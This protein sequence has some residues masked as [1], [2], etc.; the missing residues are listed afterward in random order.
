MVICLPEAA[1][2]WAQVFQLQSCI[3][4]PTR[5]NPAFRVFLQ[6]PRFREGLLV[7]ASHSSVLYPFFF[8]KPLLKVH[9]FLLASQIG[10]EAQA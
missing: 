3:V 6:T 10:E 7:L 8:Y 5:T 2:N 1:G 9:F 4:K